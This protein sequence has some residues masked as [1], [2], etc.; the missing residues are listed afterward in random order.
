MAFCGP[1]RSRPA[2]TNVENT[3]I[4]PPAAAL[5][6]AA[7]DETTVRALVVMASSPPDAEKTIHS[8]KPHKHHRAS[9]LPGMDALAGLLDGIRA[10]GAFVLRMRLDPPWSMR[11]C[12][13][14]PLTV[15]CQTH[16]RAVIV[17]ATGPPIELTAGQLAL[18]R[19]TEPYVFADDPHTRPMIV[20]HPGQ[21]CTTESGD[22]LRF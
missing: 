16:G 20:I 19:G 8:R 2:I 11:V 13:E 17:P 5:A 7:A 18:T 9:T 22:D 21:R 6:S 12:D 3:S 1:A 10:R 15:I 14:A 4:M